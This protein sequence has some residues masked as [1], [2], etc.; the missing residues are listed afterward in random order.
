MGFATFFD[1][2]TRIAFLTPA[3]S[4]REELAEV[5]SLVLLRL[6]RTWYA[7]ADGPP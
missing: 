1:V 2:S 4:T 7:R 5:F 3:L 6:R